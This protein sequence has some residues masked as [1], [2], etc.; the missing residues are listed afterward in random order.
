MKHHGDMQRAPALSASLQDLPD[1]PDALQR[2]RAFALP[3]LMG[4]TL[5]TGED[6]FVHA[7]AAAEVL[8]ILSLIH[9]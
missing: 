9:I 1:Q 2:A 8:Q 7:S 3:L 6:M 5:D 4:A